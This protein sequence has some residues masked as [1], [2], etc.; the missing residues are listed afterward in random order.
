ME[1]VGLII[2]AP[3]AGGPAGGVLPTVFVGADVRSTLPAPQKTAERR[4][5]F[6]AGR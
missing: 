6:V 3:P 5:E 1:T 2:P 4:N